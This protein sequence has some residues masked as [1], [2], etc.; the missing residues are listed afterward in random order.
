VDAILVGTGTVLADNPTLTA[1]MPDGS[2]Y[3]HQPLR[4]V[5]GE[6][7]IPGTF[8]IF[9]TD[10]AT[11]LLPTHD[12]NQALLQLKDLGVKHVWVEGGPQ[13]ASRFVA[14]N[15]VNEYVIYQAPMLLGG[16]RTALT[17]I[18]VASMPQAKHLQIKQVE[19]LGDDLLIV[20]A[21]KK[22]TN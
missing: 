5:L 14:A 9:N 10:A 6:R 11:V 12:L 16:Q 8:N 15:L 17:D 21:P 18:G 22:E 4:A 19:Q 1:R 13:V 2:L 3:P 20:A 7:P